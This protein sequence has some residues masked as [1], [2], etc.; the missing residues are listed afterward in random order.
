[1]PD[2]T[3]TIIQ[4][5]LVWENPEANRERFGETIDA[6]GEKTNLIVL[7]EMF[8]TG[9]SMNAAPLAEAMDGPSVAW[10]RKTAQ[11]TGADV[12]GSLIIG[13]DGRFFNRLVWA[14]PDGSVLAYDKRHLFRMLQEEKTYSAGDSLL[15][16]DLKGWR[17]RPFVCYDLRFPAWS[18]NMDCAYDLAIYVANWPARRAAHWKTLLAARAMENQAYV[19]GVNRVGT[20]GNGLDFSGDSSVIDPLGTVLFRQSDAPCVHTRVLSKDLLDD[21][22]HDFPAWRDADAALITFPSR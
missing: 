20:D 18:R 1:M 21:W 14:R 22:R 13:E 15:T 2:L 4:A 3:V 5:D 12:T 6:M 16:V 7:P 9:F 11:Q 8:A 10:M 17:I 19:V